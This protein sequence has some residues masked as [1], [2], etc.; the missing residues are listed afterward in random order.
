LKS[1][2]SDERS[3]RCRAT[4]P[5]IGLSL[6]E[7]RPYALVFSANG[8][9]LRVQKVGAVTPPDHTVLGS[10]VQ[11]IALVVGALSKQDVKFE[12]YQKG[13]RGR[14]GAYVPPLM[15]A[16]GL[17]ELEHNAKNDRMRAT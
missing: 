17:C 8:V 9:A 13:L 5:S 15:E 14:F 7:D 6:V 4:S 2:R 10:D 1:N 16:L 11:H 12:R 3:A